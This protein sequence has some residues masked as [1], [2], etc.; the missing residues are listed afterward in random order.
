MLTRFQSR[1]ACTGIVGYTLFYVLGLGLDS[2]V[3]FR[4]EIDT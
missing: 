4:N 1:F 2:Y 3:L